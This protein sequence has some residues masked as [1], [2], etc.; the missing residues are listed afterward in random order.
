MVS[1]QRQNPEEQ[2]SEEQKINVEVLYAYPD[3]YFLKKTASTAKR[4]HSNYYFALRRVGKIY[5]N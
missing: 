4:D 2:K 5:R 1:E 3:K